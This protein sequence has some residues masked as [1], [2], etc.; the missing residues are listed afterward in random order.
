M[1]NLITFGCSLTFDKYQK[2]WPYF[3]SSKIKL[4]LHNFGARGAG[5][6]FITKRILS[7]NIDNNSLVIIMLP[8]ADRFDLYVEKDSIQY[9]EFL[10]ISSWQDKSSPQL[11]NID[12]STTST[13]SGFCLSG[14]EHRGLKKYWYK[15]YYSQ[16]QAEI[17]FFTNILLLQNYLEN[18]NI[19]Y[20]FTSAYDLN[21]VI[22]QDTNKTTES[23]VNLDTIKSKINFEKFLLYKKTHGFLTFCKDNEVKKI[24][25][26][27]EEKGHEMYVNNVLLKSQNFVEYLINKDLLLP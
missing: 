16:S 6:S 14:G 10:M 5:L 11:V 24:R 7:S 9:S 8:S 19:D 17:D 4:N 2:T 3:L 23:K 26:Y 27:P 18:N 1:K 22:E 20:Y 25:H 12:G 13:D 15:F 21:Q